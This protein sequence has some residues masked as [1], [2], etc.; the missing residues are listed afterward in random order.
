MSSASN[1]Q[2][3]QLARIMA[4]Y[5]FETIAERRSAQL[6]DGTLM[7]VRFRLICRGKDCIGLL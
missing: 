4:R 3:G 5:G 6:C 2:H 7:R 1:T